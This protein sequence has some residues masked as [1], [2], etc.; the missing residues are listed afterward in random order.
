[1][2]CESCHRSPAPKDKNAAPVGSACSGCHT[3]DDAHDRQFGVR[4]EQCH[5]TESW[6]KIKTR[7]GGLLFESMFS[8]A[9][10][11]WSPVGDMHE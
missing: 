8:F 5:V 10:N 4:C 11:N 7:V 3:G 2:T 9:G 1:V 6:K